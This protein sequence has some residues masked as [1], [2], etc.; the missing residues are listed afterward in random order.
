[1]QPGTTT[2]VA[3]AYIQPPAVSNSANSMRPFVITKAV[4]QIAPELAD[5]GRLRAFRGLARDALR[6]GRAECLG[7]PPGGVLT[8]RKQTPSG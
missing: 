6:V 2:D 1:V 5:L 3:N 4:H 8:L 7:R